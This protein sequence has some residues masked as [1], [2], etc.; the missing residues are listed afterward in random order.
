MK[1]RLIVGALVAG[2]FMFAAGAAAPAIAADNLATN[3]SFDS[4]GYIE[5]NGSYKVGDDFDGWTVVSAQPGLDDFGMQVW[6]DNPVSGPWPEGPYAAV[7]G[8]IT[9]SIPTE[10][11][12][13]YVVDFET[14]AAGDSGIADNSGWQG[15]ITGGVAIDS[16][17]AG[18]FTT[19]TDPIYTPQSVVFT[20]TDDSTDLSFFSDTNA[21]GIDTVSVTLVP[22]DDSPIMITAIAGGLGAAALA[23]GSVHLFGRKNKRASA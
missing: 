12:K 4:P 7:Q 19:V 2:A 5:T 11:G 9:Q 17:T 16:V 23:A 14:R 10:A 20:A 21:V 15:G 3:G 22:E 1:S 18:T 6:W 8:R 13:T